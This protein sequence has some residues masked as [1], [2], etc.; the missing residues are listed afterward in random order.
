MIM[1][2]ILQVGSAV[3]QSLAGQC[4]G[5][6]SP[7][8]AV[9]N[10]DIHAPCGFCDSCCDCVKEKR[11][12]SNWRDST[13][14][15]AI[16]AIKYQGSCD[17]CRHFQY[18]GLVFSFKTRRN[19]ATEAA[20]EAKRLRHMVKKHT[21][22]VAKSG[23]HQARNRKSHKKQEWNCEPSEAAADAIAARDWMEK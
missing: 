10:P 15:R 2:Y 16:R 11:T 3:E 5:P 13:H 6:G 19:H 18:K 4:T 21:T 12:S 23:I 22:N 8:C 20:W 1:D 7:K 9:L 14:W 17:I